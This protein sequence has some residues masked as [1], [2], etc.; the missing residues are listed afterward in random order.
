MTLRKTLPIWPGKPTGPASP[1]T[2]RLVTHPLEGTGKK[3]VSNRAGANLIFG[4]TAAALS[5]SSAGRLNA[6]WGVFEIDEASLPQAAKEIEPQ[7]TL[8]LNLFRDQLDRYG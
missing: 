2:S 8:V 3:V 4:V 5:K 1:T 7:A 6:D